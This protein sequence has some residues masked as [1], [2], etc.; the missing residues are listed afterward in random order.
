MKRKILLPV[1]SILLLPL[2]SWGP[3]GHSTI[4]L[5]AQH[6]LTVKARAAVASILKTETMVSVSSWADAYRP[7]HKETE[8]WHFLNLNLGLNQQQFNDVV[9]KQGTA[10]VYNELNLLIKELADPKTP[11]AKKY[12]DL[13]FLI[14]F[15]GDAH[16][17]MHVSREIDRGGGLI[18]VTYDMVTNLHKVWDGLLIKDDNSNYVQLAAKVDHATPA[19]VQ[20]WQ[21]DAILQWLW[22]S[23][24]ISS[25]V[26][27]EVHKGSVLDKNYYNRN[28]ATAEMRLD[29]GG[30]RLAGVL[31]KIFQ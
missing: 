30:I 31:N 22:E 4:A 7:K 19:Q 21:K 13:K 6:H 25:K 18:P 14:H 16:Q 12:T 11:R 15:V 17:P 23:Y 9:L 29:M 20:Q 2:V 24:Q 28:I 8:G 10:N 3:E 26:Y 5:I 27:G 1:L